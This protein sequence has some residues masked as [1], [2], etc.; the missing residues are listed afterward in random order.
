MIN[1]TVR[2]LARAHERIDAKDCIP[3]QGRFDSD[4]DEIFKPEKRER[5]DQKQFEHGH[6]SGD[7]A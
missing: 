2:S 1:E 4:F 6:N 5:L 7:F 3:D